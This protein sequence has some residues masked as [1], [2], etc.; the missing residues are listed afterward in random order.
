[1][2]VSPHDFVHGLYK[3]QLLQQ[4]GEMQSLYLCEAPT[5]EAIKKQD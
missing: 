5:Q 1:M 3:D 2:P 4:G